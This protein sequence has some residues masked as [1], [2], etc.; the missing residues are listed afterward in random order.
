MT[1]RTLCPLRERGILQAQNHPCS[2]TRKPN[3]KNELNEAPRPSQRADP[4][5]PQMAAPKQAPKTGPIFVPKPPST[6]SWGTPNADQI[7]GHFPDPVLGPQKRTQCFQNRTAVA[8]KMLLTWTRA[9]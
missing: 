4:D 7:L 1:N 2:K 5:G 9:Q 8:K 6:D 3:P